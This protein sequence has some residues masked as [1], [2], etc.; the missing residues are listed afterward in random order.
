M[1]TRDNGCVYLVNAGPGDLVFLTRQGE[2]ALR[3]A[4]VVVCDPEVSSDVARLAPAGAELIAPENWPGDPGKSSKKLRAFM[5][6]K[7]LGGKHVAVLSAGTIA[8]ELAQALADERV[9]IEL[10]PGVS[11]PEA[12]ARLAGFPLVHA[13]MSPGYTLIVDP[14]EPG[15]G[16]VDWPHQASL[17][18]TLVVDTRLDRVPHIIEAVRS[19]GRSLDTPAALIRWGAAAAGKVRTGRLADLGQPEAKTE[20]GSRVALVVGEV[21]RLGTAMSQA[22]S[23]GLAGQTLVVTRARHQAEQLARPLRDH[24]GQVLNIPVIKI[25][26]PTEHLPL[27]EALVSLN[28]YDWIVFTSANGVTQFF[29]YF[30]KKYKDMRDIGGVRIAAVGPGTAERITELHLQVDVTPEDF[31]AVQVALAMRKFES[32][33]NRRILLLRAELANPELPRKLESL[34]AIVDDIACY[35]TE[36]ETTG[37]E[38]ESEQLRTYGA[39]WVTFTSGSTVEHFHSRF[40]LPGL[41]RKFPQL[42]V[43]SIG[44]EASQA[45]K[46]LGITPE[47]E[48]RPHTIEGLV[49]AI[50]AAVAASL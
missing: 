42:R 30:F 20:M 46:T 24:G 31:T 12:V 10:V 6:K 19:S 45:L 17:P 16:E 44:P 18:G 36:G 21:V 32:L 5:V 49:S 26:H 28:G 23:R 33:D 4:D 9:R 48:A 3:R 43:A 13:G 15:L 7:A 39:D 38:K 50:E 2:D 22:I 14:V 8:G 1:A 41:R 27:A 34:G 40:D 47:I 35:R 25:G 11:V 29:H 37:S